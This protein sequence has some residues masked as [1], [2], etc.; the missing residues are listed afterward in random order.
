MKEKIRFIVISA[1]RKTQWGEAHDI[2][3]EAQIARSRAQ[4]SLAIKDWRVE[5]IRV[6]Q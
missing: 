4:Q 5:E 2:H 6:L 3:E 1:D